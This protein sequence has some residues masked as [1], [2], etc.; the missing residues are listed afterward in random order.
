M[1]ELKWKAANFNKL[2]E[3]L[4]F[5]LNIVDKDFKFKADALEQV[6]LK[7][8]NSSSHIIYNKALDSV[9]IAICKNKHTSF[10]KFI[11]LESLSDTFRELDYDEKTLW[12]QFLGLLG[13]RFYK[14]LPLDYFQDK[15]K[16]KVLRMYYGGFIYDAK[17]AIGLGYAL[18]AKFGK[19]TYDYDCVGIFKDDEGEYL[20][21]SNW[22]T[23]QK[24]KLHRN[25]LLEISQLIKSFREDKKEK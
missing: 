22:L 14:K 3:R 10:D 15:E 4:R 8:M 23:K 13:K 9:R 16:Q 19:H 18:I 11:K 12:Q 6:Y 20:A 21:L 7:V 1:K 5:Y 24:I 17:E 25:Y 2:W